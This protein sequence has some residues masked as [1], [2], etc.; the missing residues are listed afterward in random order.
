[1]SRAGDHAAMI[2]ND[3]DVQQPQS[4]A[5]QAVKA[6]PLSE[7]IEDHLLSAVRKLTAILDVGGVC[8]AVLKG[9]EQVYGATS[10]WIMLHDPASNVLRTA[11]FR[12][13]GADVYGGVEI[14][15]DSGI[16]GLVF[17]TREIQFIPDARKEHRWFNPER[18]RASGL[19]SVFVLP[20]IAGG[21]TIGILGIDSPR[22][23][24]AQPPT[25]AG[26]PAGSRPAA[27]SAARATGAAAAGGRSPRRDSKRIL[28]RTD[29]RRERRHAA[30]T[31]RTAAGC[32]F[33]CNRVAARGDRDRKGAARA[34]PARA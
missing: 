10:S 22:F 21:K 34:S 19:Q 26:K 14:P 9:V 17:T 3:P 20:L 31:L 4:W 1:M 30:R 8:E 27:R 25:P 12:G 11:L 7:G 15:A 32:R 2:E 5:Y 33:G 24:P 18:V 29:R 23:G 13:R 16:A 28:V 6:L